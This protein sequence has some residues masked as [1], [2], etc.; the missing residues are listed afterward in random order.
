[1]IMDCESCG[2]DL[3]AYLDGELDGSRVHE[4]E[5]HLKKCPP[6]LEELQSLK[7]ASRMIDSHLD[8]LEPRPEIW[9][10]LVK[11][12]DGNAVS[13]GPAGLFQFFVSH[14]WKTAAAAL[15]TSIVLFGGVVGVRT[16]QQSEKTFRQY[17]NDYVQ[18]R[19]DQEHTYRVNLGVARSSSTDDTL[20]HSEFAEN[21]FAE[22][23]PQEPDNPFRSEE[24]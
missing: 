20:A 17:M 5:E 19:D 6:C 3:T 14:R 23:N 11:R 21:P 9:N 18:R 15:A 1:M 4:L 12:I 7:L 2:D 24:Q 13:A 8:E 22:I 16:H 10:N